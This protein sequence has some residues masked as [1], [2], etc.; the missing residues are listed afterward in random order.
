M[1]TP[2]KLMVLADLVPGQPPAGPHQVAPG[3]AGDLLAK[4]APEMRL[5]D[6]QVEL[7]FTSLEDFTPPSVQKGRQELAAN[8]AKLTAVLHHPLFQALESA[9]RGL[10]YLARAL[11]PEG[12]ELWV[13]PTSRD[14]VRSR[15]YDRVFKPEYD[16]VANPS[17][18]VLLD[19]D[20]DHKPAS[21]A[22]LADLAKMGQAMSVPL[23]AQAP[24]SFFGVKTLLHLPALG[25]LDKRLAGPDYT[26]FTAFRQK[27][28]ATWLSLMVNR[29]LLRPPFEGLAYTEPASAGEPESYLWGRAVWLLGANLV[30]AWARDGMPIGISGMGLGGEQRGLALRDL[31]ISRKET[32]KTPLEA[33]FPL[34]LTE[35]LPYF[36]LSPITQLPGEL[37]GAQTPDAV[38]L[39]LAANLRQFTDPT[40]ARPGLLLVYATLA[41][42]LSLGRASNLALSLAPEMAGL[43]PAEAAAQLQQRLSG[44]LGPLGQ[45]EMAVTPEDGALHVLH[46]PSARI[47]GKNF[48]LE[49]DVPLPG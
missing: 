25:G 42:A 28:E 13:L 35:M 17:G 29:F 38:Y 24:A 33:V 48:E 21:L 16:G 40:Q 14:E 20:F 9:W 39:H 18:A 5:G 41:Y 45:G 15:F 2:F 47:H 12:V 31:P 49:F 27:E 44:E 43:A 4:L 34:D 10:D 36:G 30:R 6:P 22:V 23:A 3:G 1:P 8:P 46:K 37:G 26:S 19:F 11:P 32:V 7:K